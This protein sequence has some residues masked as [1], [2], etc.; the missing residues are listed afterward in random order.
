MPKVNDRVVYPTTTSRNGNEIRGQ[1]ATSKRTVDKVLRA[2]EFAKA[3]TLT[4]V[5]DR[6]EV[7]EATVYKV[8]RYVPEAK[9]LI[10]EGHMGRSRRTPTIIPEWARGIKVPFEKGSRHL[11][12][13]SLEQAAITGDTV[14]D[15][16][17]AIMRQT[18]IEG[19]RSRRLSPKTQRRLF[20]RF[21]GRNNYV[22]VNRAQDRHELIAS[23][24]RH[25]EIMNRMDTLMEAV[26][27]G[28]LK[29]EFSK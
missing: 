9:R 1:W 7:S 18:F 3:Q 22:A 11:S 26:D 16:D 19:L 10:V 29:I 20:E 8:L 13:D 27:N 14:V 24:R 2:I 25:D 21:A 4:A 17:T 5:A 12:E 28:K 6:A 23:Q 15:E